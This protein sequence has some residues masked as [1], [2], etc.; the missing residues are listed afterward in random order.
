VQL[1]YANVHFLGSKPYADLPRFIREFDV[2]VLPWNQQSTFV[3]YGSAMKVREY[4][5]TGK[6]VVISPMYEY[7]N[8]PGVR[9]YRTADE[10]I[11]L[12]EDS[13]NNDT[14]RELRQAQVQDATWEARTR[15]ACEVMKSLLRTSGAPAITT[16]GVQTVAAQSNPNLE[17]VDRT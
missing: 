3:S 12:V 4:L 14:D 17:T 13:L 15:Q 6:P 1:D 9:I 16:A 7:M 8:T 5:A 10:F 2:C 11:R